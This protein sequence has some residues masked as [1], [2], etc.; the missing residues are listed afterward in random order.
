MA[1]EAGLMI[2]V[3]RMSRD[4]RAAAATLS[5]MEAR[6]L[7]DSYY[8]HQEDRIRANNRV[9]A[10]TES[11]EPHAVV[12]WLATQSDTI[13]G[14]IKGA[15]ERYA[16]AHPVGAWMMSVRG[17]GPVISAGLL[18]N[19]DITRST[20]V[21]NLWAF[22]GQAPGRDKRV[23]GEKLTFN[24]SLKRLAW[25]IGESFKRT[26]PEHA[27]AFYRRVYD[28]RKAYEIAKN[29]AGDYA[30][31]AAKALE[32]KKYRDD[33][34]AKAFYLAG[35]LPPGQIDRRACRYAAKLFLAHVHEKLWWHHY[36]S[37]PPYPYPMPYAIAHLGHAH[38]IDPPN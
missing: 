1:D 27:D 22:A 32:K 6:Y 5:D 20:T 4:I 16:A 25:I 8:Q 31:Q 35:K 3:A 2:P 28:E 7:V 23:K 30:D 24:P 38:K 10:M 12:G 14:Q 33:T 34:K 19:I 13:E 11:E 17:I 9:R 26:S 18:A 37:A 36:G 21:G 29:E 15:L